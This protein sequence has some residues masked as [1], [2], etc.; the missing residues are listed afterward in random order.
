MEI[1]DRI[2]GII[3][4]DNKLLMMRG[5]SGLLWTPGGKIENNETDEECLKRELKEET[6]LDLISMRF[7]G[8]TLGKSPMFREASRNKIYLIKAK[9]K[10]MVPQKERYVHDLFWINVKD[11]L[12]KKYKIMTNVQESVLDFLIKERI[13]R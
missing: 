3:I 2:A 12:G 13:W 8:E 6:N 7:V 11:Y 5:K 10:L 9:G 1:R 4:K